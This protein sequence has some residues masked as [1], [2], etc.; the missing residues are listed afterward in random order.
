MNE[1]PLQIL[2]SSAQQLYQKTLHALL[3]GEEVSSVQQKNTIGSAWG[4]RE[5][6]TRELRYVNLVLENSRDRIINSREFNLER[7][8][9]RAIISTLSDEI[10]L[11]VMEF[12]DPRAAEFC[13]N[14]K[15]ILTSYGY[16]IRHFDGIDQIQLIIKQLKEDPNTRRAIIH[17]HSPGDHEV[18]YTPCI[19]SLHFLIR[20]GV[21]EC[22]AFWRSE[23]ALTLLPYNLFEFTM[24]QEL[25]ASEL[26]IP[27]GCFVQT[28]TSLHYY[29]EDQKRLEK[30]L[31]QMKKNSQPLPMP[32]MPHHSLSQIDRLRNLEKKLRLNTQLITSGD[33]LI[34]YWQD[35]GDVL[36]FCIFNK[37]GRDELA[38]SVIEHSPWK[39]L[40]LENSPREANRAKSREHRHHVP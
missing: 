11:D 2:A 26:E 21:L 30:C 19:D 39:G 7:A 5:R 28:V 35:I 1:M 15:T 33:A 37:K 32:P 9:S 20:N 29:L 36:S 25:I 3:E 23:N 38:L 8:I 24:L 16:R 4:T 31:K 34:D 14:G 6:P 10:N 18:R 13:D 12:Y 22:Q 40:I 17:V 27:V